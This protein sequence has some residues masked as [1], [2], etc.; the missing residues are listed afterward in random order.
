MVAASVRRAIGNSALLLLLAE[1][2]AVSLMIW[3]PSRHH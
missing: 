3:Y 2:A 1:M